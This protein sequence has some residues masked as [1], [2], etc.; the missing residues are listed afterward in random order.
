MGTTLFISASVANVANFDLVGVFVSLLTH[1]LAKDSQ[2]GKALAPVI[3][4]HDEA[5]QVMKKGRASS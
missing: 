1:A 2:L 4:C 5:N 3:S